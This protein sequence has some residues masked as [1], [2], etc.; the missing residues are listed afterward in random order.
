MRRVIK[1]ANYYTP[2]SL[3]ISEEL[4][5]KVKQIAVQNKRSANKEIAFAL[6]QYVR[7]YEAKFGEIKTE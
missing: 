5:D 7:E 6:E 3:R 2:F 1:M 4:L